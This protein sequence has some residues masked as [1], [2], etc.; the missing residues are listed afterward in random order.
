MG[1][2]FQSVAVGVGKYPHSISPVRGANG[3]CWNT[4]PF[5]IVPALGQVSK[6]TSH[7]RV[8]QETWD[9]LH[10][11]EAG[12]K[13]ANGSD[14]FRPQAGSC[15]VNPCT[16]SGKTEVLTGEA[17]AQKIDSRNGSPI[18]GAD[19]SI[20]LHS[21]PMPGE[22]TLTVGINLDLPRDTESGSFK[23]K[24]KPSNTRE[25]TT[26]QHVSSRSHWRASYEMPPQS[27][28]S[29]YRAPDNSF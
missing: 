25:E 3:T 9:V 17:P 1:V 22:D 27:S 16:F 21:W 15:A 28:H 11:D 4:I 5:R 7:V 14:V 24:V 29:V 20:S 18:D 19:V 10:E 12:S 26:D 2:R 23:A 6:Y 8:R 13:M